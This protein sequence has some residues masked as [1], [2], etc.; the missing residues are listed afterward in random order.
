MGKQYLP[1]PEDRVLVTK[2][3][4]EGCS[5]QEIADQMGRTTR[6]ICI[7]YGPNLKQGRD[8]ALE[9]GLK[10]KI[11]SKTG[12]MQVE[13][14]SQQREMI[15]VLSGQGLRDDQVA[16]LVKIPLQTM[17]VYCR[18]DL[19][20]GKAVA[21][22]KVTKSLFEMAL[23]K[24]HVNATMFYL[25]TQCGWKETSN[26]EFPDKN[27][28]PQAIAGGVNINISADKMQTLIALLN[29]TV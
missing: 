25:K 3:A 5:L 2:M 11:N 21:H 16:I 26:I 22:D 28:N 24:E 17:L 9:A 19:N 1:T 29:D 15:Q 8:M 6:M 12:I 20:I 27:G 10:P 23:D 13:I 4:S 14:T 7:K 18:E